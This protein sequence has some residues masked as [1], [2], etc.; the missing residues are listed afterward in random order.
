MTLAPPRPG[1]ETLFWDTLPHP[2]SLLTALGAAAWRLLRR[3]EGGWKKKLEGPGRGDPSSRAARS[4]AFCR[5]PL[6]R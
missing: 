3:H 4:P 1:L 6:K 5:S 2:V